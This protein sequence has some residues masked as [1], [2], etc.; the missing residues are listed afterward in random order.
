MKIIYQSTQRSERGDIIGTE[1]KIRCETWAKVLPLSAKRFID[2][3]V[4]LVNEL[5]YRIVLRFRTNIAPDDI[6]IWRGKRLRQIA[7]AYDAESRKIWTVL[8]CVEMVKDGVS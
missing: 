3:S 4:E 5:S 7:P 2:E 6:V 1:D 8:E